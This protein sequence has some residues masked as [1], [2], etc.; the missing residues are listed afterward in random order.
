M[1]T[2][3]HDKELMKLRDKP[4]NCFEQRRI[5]EDKQSCTVGLNNLKEGGWVVSVVVVVWEC[6]HG[7]SEGG[8]LFKLKKKTNKHL[9]TVVSLIHPKRCS[10]QAG[11]RRVEP[12][13]GNGRSKCHKDPV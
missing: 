10:L 6:V 3:P 11:C 12:L 7:G 5:A 9:A 8:L 13:T 4:S 1:T 2:W